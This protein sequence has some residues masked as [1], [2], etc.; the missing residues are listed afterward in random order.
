MFGSLV[1]SELCPEAF[2]A[3][4]GCAGPRFLSI[5]EILF[6]SGVSGISSVEYN[7]LALNALILNCIYRIKALSN[8]RFLQVVRGKSFV[9]GLE[10]THDSQ[11]ISPICSITIFSFFKMHLTAKSGGIPGIL[12]TSNGSIEKEGLF[13]SRNTTAPVSVMCCL[14]LSATEAQTPAS[15]S[16][17]TGTP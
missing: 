5:R 14:C 13:S 6:I 1:G 3:E 4:A 8:A 15:F 10:L 2:S 16:P 11:V 9:T 12:L 17:S 7:T